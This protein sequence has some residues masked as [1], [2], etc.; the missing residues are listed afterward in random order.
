MACLWSLPIDLPSWS[1]R[2]LINSM[3]ITHLWH[4]G[5]S[6]ASW[7]VHGRMDLVVHRVRISHHWH[8]VRIRSCHLGRGHVA[9]RGI[10][11]MWLRHYVGSSLLM[12][13]LSLRKLSLDVLL[14]SSMVVH[15]QIMDF[16]CFFSR[17]LRIARL[18]KT[19]G[20]LVLERLLSH[21]ML[22][23][24]LLVHHG[25]RETLRLAKL[26]TSNICAWYRDSLCNFVGGLTHTRANDTL[27]IFTL[28]FRHNYKF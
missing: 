2:S 21:W 27:L 10:G 8:V 26:S 1:V 25:L 17:T 9:G 18:H 16:L 6:K 23:H 12:E 11:S 19:A 24:R 3:G 15:L 4:L 20:R 14:H 7:V 22:E 28:F 13:L 5:H